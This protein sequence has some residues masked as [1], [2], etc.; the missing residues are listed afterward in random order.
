M[1]AGIFLSAGIILYFIDYELSKSTPFGD[2]FNMG[3]MA[4]MMC[5]LA[6]SLVVLTIKDYALRQKRL[7]PHAIGRIDDISIKKTWYG[8]QKIF[9]QYSY[10]VSDREYING[11]FD[12]A[13]PFATYGQLKMHPELRDFDNINDLEGKMIAVYYNKESP[14]SSAISRRLEQS[15]LVTTIPSCFV[16]LFCLYYLAKIFLAIFY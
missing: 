1:W 5:F 14:W 12:F 4:V 9:L 2:G 11:M 15:V 8:K 13:Q 6:V 7:W 16:I 3:S 10:M